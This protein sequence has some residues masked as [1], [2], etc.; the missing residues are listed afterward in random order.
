VTS[1]RGQQRRHRLPR[2]PIA[3]ASTL[4][5]LAAF[6]AFYALGRA[7]AGTSSRLA[8]AT[9]LVLHSTRPHVPLLGRAAA[10]PAP[11]PAR[12]PVSHPVTAPP[13]PPSAPPPPKIVHVTAPPPKQSSG[14]RV[15]SGSSVGAPEAVPSNLG[16]ARWASSNGSDAAPGSRSAPFRTVS[17]LGLALRPGQ[18]GCLVAGST[19]NE[20]VKLWRTGARGSPIKI[21]TQGS[22]AAVIRGSVGISW[23]AHDVVLA[24]V[25]IDGSDSS[26]KATVT[27]HGARVSLVRDEI[28]GTGFRN[29]SARCVDLDYADAAVLDGDEIH[30]C[31][32]VTRPGSYAPG[33]VVRHANSVVIRNSTI[34]NVPG[35]GI[36]LGPGA[37]G[38]LIK[39]DVVDGNL[40]GILIRGAD[41]VVRNSIVSNSGRF[42]VH[43]G[44]PLGGGNVVA[45]NCLWSARGALATGPG[46][47]FVGN[48]TADP[49]YA[50]RPHGVGPGPCY[51]KRPTEAA[52]YLGTPWPRLHGITVH[53]R[54][55]MRRGRVEFDELSLS[56]LDPR[57]RVVVACGYGCFGSNQLPVSVVGTGDASELTGLWIP[58]GARIEVRARRS[59]WVGAYARV[60]LI[61]PPHGV[62]VSHACLSPTAGP[63]PVPCRRY[64]RAR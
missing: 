51:D 11:P 55:R 8:G 44:R 63:A 23:R 29:R 13:P 2:T 41:N 20:N 24:A 14:A 21:Q 9:R 16:C 58:K 25:H 30:N 35:N 10:L 12:H 31:A 50:S 49:R 61:G 26:A 60:L 37:T 17:R 27:V 64:E 53:Y 46:I 47:H 4:A 3:L 56:G 59:G 19:F 38:T 45:G 62:V 57:S 1:G 40:S 54:L 42:N 36:A 52:T 34:Y 5:A 7:T 48:V 28:T 43:S 18:T 6:G 39:H 33:I 22:P 32:V 15:L